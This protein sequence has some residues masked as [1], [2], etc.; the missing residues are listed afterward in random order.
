LYFTDNA[1]VICTSEYKSRPSFDDFYLRL[2]VGV[3]FTNGSFV[4][5]QDVD[6]LFAYCGQYSPPAYLC[7][8]RSIIDG[9][10][11]YPAGNNGGNGGYIA[12]S[13]MGGGGGG[14]GSVGLNLASGQAGCGGTG[15]AS[16]ISGAQV[17]YAGGG[18]A[19]TSASVT[20]NGLGAAGGGN[21]AC[22]N[23]IQATAGLN[24]TGSGGGAGQGPNTPAGNGGSGIVILRYPS[25][26]APATSTTGSP[27][28]YIAGAW[29]V[30]KFIASGT[31]TF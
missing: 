31:I 21:G 15:I 29:R 19:S 25:Y 2:M 16:S 20:G 17:F 1:D 3:Y 8:S 6:T 13:Y 12:P 10:S 5:Y 7:N 9:T 26:L 23:N 27:E 18:G 30:Y 22:S 14:A 28:T 11:Q 4:G 24:N